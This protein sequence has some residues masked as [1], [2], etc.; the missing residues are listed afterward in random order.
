VLIGKILEGWKQDGGTGP[1][2]TLASMYVDQF[3]D[4]DLARKMSKDYGVPIYDTIEQALTLGSGRIAVDGA[5]SIGEH[6][7]LSLERQR[8]AALSAA[9]IHGGDHCGVH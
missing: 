7:R 5:I 9:A 3:P 6:G 1:A 4:A 2:L 8:A